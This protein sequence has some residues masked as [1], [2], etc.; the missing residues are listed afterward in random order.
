M[1][2]MSTLPRP[3]KISADAHDNNVRLD[4]RWEARVVFSRQSFTLESSVLIAAAKHSF[5]STK[6]NFYSKDFYGENFLTACGDR[7]SP[8]GTVSGR[9]IATLTQDN[10]Q[11]TRQYCA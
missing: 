10:N 5:P 9:F 2:E 7:F 1:S 3:G 11:S 8:V 6:F 4:S